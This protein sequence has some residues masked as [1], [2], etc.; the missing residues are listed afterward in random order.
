[1]LYKYKLFLSKA[2]SKNLQRQGF[3][4]HPHFTGG[5]TEAEKISQE[6]R[7]LGANT[8]QGAFINSISFHLIQAFMLLSW[9]F[10]FLLGLWGVAIRE[11]HGMGV[12]VGRAPLVISQHCLCPRL[13]LP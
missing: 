3:F 1:M 13:L 6:H 8:T 2:T 7:T 9:R 12:E 10:L 5:E 4:H 11:D